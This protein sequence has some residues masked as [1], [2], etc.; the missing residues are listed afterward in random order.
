MQDEEIIAAVRPYTSVSRERILN[1]LTLVESVVREG[2]PGD[3]AEVG[4][5]K[6]GLIMAMALKCRQLGAEDR[7]IH[8]YDTFT[9]MTPPTDRDVDLDGHSAASIFASVS[10]EASLDEVQTTLARLNYPNLRIHRCDITT[11]DPSTFPTFALLRLDTDW[12]E[13]TKYE[14]THMEPRVSLGGY[15]I[16]DDYGHWRGSRAA[17]DEFRPPGLTWIDYTGV[18]WRKDYGRSR[19][20]PTSAY[21]TALRENFQH[22]VGLYDAV[23]RSFH[24]GCGSYLFDGQTYEYQ[25]ATLAKQEALFAAGQSATR[26]LEVGVYLGHSLLILLLANPTLRITCIDNDSSFSPA[27]VAYLNRHFGDRITFHLGTAEAVL[28]RETLGTFDCVHI[29]ADHTPDA[30]ARQFS[31]TRPFADVGATYV[32]DDYEAVRSVID[33]WVSEGL[34]SHVTTPW[35]LWTNTITRLNNVSS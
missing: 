1:V 30:V 26:V 29:D 9:G 21:T 34:L 15:V 33:G 23:G 31:L 8:A 2:I 10:C 7:V 19:I 16:V 6:G 25:T 14:L 32:F 20:V 13:S 24:R 11:V 18:W 22:V 27:A 35:C 28:A 3:F 5:W 12:Y 4:V 17:V